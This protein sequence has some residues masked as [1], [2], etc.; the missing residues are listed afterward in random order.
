MKNLK[1]FL[2]LNKHDGFEHRSIQSISMYDRLKRHTFNFDVDANTDT[3]FDGKQSEYGTTDW[4]ENF[5]SVGSDV[6]MS[7]EAMPSNAHGPPANC[8]HTNCPLYKH[9][10]AFLRRHFR[11]NP[12]YWK[13]KLQQYRQQ[14]IQKQQS[15]I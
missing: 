13:R 8:P 11:K 7:G 2:G 4:R 12:E 15:F 10:K 3:E 14:Q 9:R 1:I 6:K 5:R